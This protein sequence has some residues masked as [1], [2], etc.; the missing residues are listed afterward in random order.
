M[1][2]GIN[3]M[4]QSF[5]GAI[6]ASLIVVIIRSGSEIKV[7]PKMGFIAGM[8]WI[9]IVTKPYIT[10]NFETKIHAFWNIVVTL[11]VTSSLSI[12]FNMMTVEQ[13]SDFS[14]FGS[15]GFI[16]MM[17]ALPTSLFWDR[18]NITNLYDRWYFRRR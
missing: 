1:A 9:Y 5:T 12:M 18:Q 2:Y 11:V 17:V 13:L 10:K 15:S 3:D 6:I 7:D 14:F 8:I 4:K 16:I